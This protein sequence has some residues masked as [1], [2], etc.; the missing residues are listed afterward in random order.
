[1]IIKEMYLN[2]IKEILEM[3]MNV[4]GGNDMHS[5]RSSDKVTI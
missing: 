1:M 4:N 2:E 3:K 5:Q